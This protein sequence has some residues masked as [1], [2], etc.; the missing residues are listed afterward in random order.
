MIPLFSIAQIREADNFA[1]SQLG[2]PGIVLMENA[3]ISIFNIVKERFAPVKELP[4]GFVCGKGNNGGD[5][6]T[7]AR[8]FLNEGYKV[9]LVHIGNEE[10]LIGD[11]QSNFQIIKQLA[12]R[13]TL[14]AIYKYNSLKDIRSLKDCQI[15]F[16]AILGTGS[17]GNLKSPFLEIVQELNNLKAFRVAIDIP[18]GLNAD[19]GYAEIVFNA[20]LTIS[21]AELKRGLF[22]G[23]GATYSGDIKKGYIGT[24][25][26]YFKN[27]ST[28]DYLIEPEDAYNCLPKRRKDLHKYSAGKI[29]ILAG[30]GKVPG[31][32][33]LT[34]NAV[35][36]V[37][38][39]AAYLCFPNSS[40]TLAQRKVTEVII[41]TYDDK[42][43][44]IFSKDNIKELKKRF[45]WADVL[46]MGPALGREEVTISGILETIKKFKS[47]RIILDAD[48][49]YALSD[50]RYKSYD[51]RN[52]VLTPHHG[53][54]A[55]LIGI[56]N[57]DLKQNKL[58]I[59]KS[60]AVEKK[61]YL[62]LKGAPT[63]IFNPGG[64]ALINTTGNAGMA[65]FGTGDVLTGVIAG[66]LAQAKNI[67]GAVVAGVYIHS[68]AADLLLKEKTEYGITASAISDNLPNSI[69]FL[70]SSIV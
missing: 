8:H 34:S 40:R 5:G 3:S 33:F 44:G 49:I 68:L 51:I 32:A 55:N 10:D 41:E 31:A 21:L 65:K 58:E 53:E 61:C 39:G 54:F 18:S 69:N 22:F 24:P 17:K 52:F 12:D 45:E 13:S 47:K 6:F 14:A 42:K 56:S 1:I 50:G 16:D 20:D 9:K 19:T 25:G 7:V 28:S 4:I 38:A 46:A 15:V 66:F 57:Q 36:K 23:D 2:I 60:F 29:A 67:E 59:G 43:S 64:E 35:F 27:L 37:G 48:A 62:V 11:A 63:I 70:R 30:T 26:S